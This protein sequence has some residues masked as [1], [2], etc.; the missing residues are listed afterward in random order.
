M[1]DARHRLPTGRDGLASVR[2][3]AQW[4]LDYPAEATGLDFPFDRPYLDLY[5]RCHIALRAVDAF[6]RIPLEDQ[7][8]MSS[9]A[10]LHRILAPV[11]SDLSFRQITQRLRCRAKLFDE[12]RDTLHLAAAPPRGISSLVP[13]PW[14]PPGD[15]TAEDLDKMHEQLD[16]LVSSLQERRPK[17]GPAQD[18]R[19]AIALILDHIDRHGENLWAH[20]IPLPENAGG[21]IRLV[22]RTNFQI[23]NLFKAMKHGERQRSG[24]KHLTQDLEHLPAEA[25]LVHNLKCP[26]YVSIICGSLDRLAEAF[27]KLDREERERRLQG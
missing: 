3:M 8:V 18:T 14:G 10:R 16:A 24:R 15:E 5:D 9:L 12:L 6:L 2:A 25:M 7:K 26:D 21:G 27:A 17:R 20:A 11:D 22:P 19:E 4:T 1:A 13:I 23:E